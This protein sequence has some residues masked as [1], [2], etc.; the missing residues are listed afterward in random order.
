[1]KKYLE[2]KEIVVLAM[3]SV[4]MGVVFVGLDSI[5]QPLQVIAGPLGGDLIYGIYLI[6]AILSMYLVRKPGAAMVGSLFTG[7]VNL[8]MGSPY[9]IHIIVAS[10]LQ[11]LGVEVGTAIGGYKKFSFINVVVSGILAMIFVTTRDYFVFGFS[12][13]GS[14]VPMMLAI[15]VISSIVFG[16]GLSVAIGSGLK[17]TGVL[18]GF[19]IAREEY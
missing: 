19:K 13:L 16:A 1:M 18:S 4:I 6:S 11:G 3:I 10:C 8:L 9:G 2:L 17:K 12:Y 15:R 14:L 5:Y 7:C